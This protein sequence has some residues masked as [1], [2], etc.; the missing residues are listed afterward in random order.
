[1]LSDHQGVTLAE[2]AAARQEAVLTAGT[3]RVELD[4]LA[5]GW[6]RRRADG[7]TGV[8]RR[9]PEGVGLRTTAYREEILFSARGTS[10][11]HSTTWIGVPGDPGAR[12]HGIRVR[13]TGSIEGP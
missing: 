12:W 7:S 8:A 10:N 2:I 5:G 3:V 6:V 13:P 9:L 11:L 4:T 1:M